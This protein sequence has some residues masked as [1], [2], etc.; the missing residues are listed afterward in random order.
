MWEG[1]NNDSG[2]MILT[3]PNHTQRGI[4]GERHTA[5]SK[6]AAC[7]RDDQSIRAA[8]SSAALSRICTIPAF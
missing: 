6:R 1:W 2:I 5:R 4:Q 8:L 7:S 3:Q